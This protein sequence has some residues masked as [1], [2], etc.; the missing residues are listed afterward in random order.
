[1]HIPHNS[2]NEIEHTIAEYRPHIL[3]ISE[4]NFH[5]SHRLEDVQIDN[6]NLY[7]ADPLKNPQLNISRVA[8]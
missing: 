3:G 7:M 1:M 4:A 8:V 2:I 5:S 6:Y